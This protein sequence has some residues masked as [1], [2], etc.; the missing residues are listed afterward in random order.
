M[1]GGQVIGRDVFANLLEQ[2][3]GLRQ[4][5]G[6]VRGAWFAELPWENKTELLFELEM[7]L[8]GLA[9]FGNVRNYPGPPERTPA[10]ARDF[11]EE[12]RVVREAIDRV[13]QLCRILLGDK[14][15]AYTFSRYLETVLPDD[16]ERSRLMQDQLTQKTPEESLFVLRNTFAT[17][18][19]IVDGLLRLGQT[20]HRQF[21]A[22]QTTVAREVG[23]NTFFNPLVALEFQPEFDRIRNPTVLEALN[24]VRFDT[25]HRVAALSFLSMF[26]ARAY[27]QVV[28]RYA[29]DPELTRLAYV[30]FSV[31][32]SDV[33]ALSRFLGRRA[34]DVVADGLE[35]EIMAMPALSV[36]SDRDKLAAH[37]GEA[38]ALR[39]HLESTAHALRIETKRT[40]EKTLPAIDR[41]VTAESLAPQL[42]DATR[43]LREMLNH[44][45]RQLCVQL[46]PGSPEPDLVPSAEARRSASERLRR[47]I[48]MFL[49]ILRG[50]LAK[51][52]VQHEQS[53]LWSTQ[54][55]L[56]FVRE[57]IGHFRAIG[58][59]LV[60]G[61]D[62]A[63]LEPFL[64]ALE[65]LR[66][67]DLL[68]A[69]RLS[70]AL[71]SCSEFYSYLEMLFEQVNRRTELKG[72]TFDR[73][74]AADTLRIYLGAN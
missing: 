50:F 66:A 1:N 44:S 52:S 69:D 51:A 35:R 42:T 15:R 20:T 6:S 36:V 13:V 26:R 38:A 10:V 25:T 18:L 24:T 9:S 16:T 40:F 8:K 48:W 29:A 19:E 23:R 53:D 21:A 17:Q 54:Q 43:T 46:Q 63:H 72:H 2:T 28:D 49:Q 70:E 7:L 31:F 73:R 37:L 59:Q 33:R 65:K 67:I 61:T 27:L 56:E 41:G 34:K 57:F 5:Q 47:D 64:A 3:R 14:D 11:H 30:M 55:G 39:A 12:L 22:V 4:D 58:Y 62:Q 71:E 60:R 32:R 45:I 68:H 74:G